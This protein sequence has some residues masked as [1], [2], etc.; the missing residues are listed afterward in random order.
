VGVTNARFRFAY[1]PVCYMY[2]VAAVAWAVGGIVWLA[3]RGRKQEAS[4]TAS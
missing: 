2:D 1:E 4:C 3:R